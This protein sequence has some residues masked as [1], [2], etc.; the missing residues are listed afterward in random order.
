MTSP[1]ADGKTHRFSTKKSGAL[2]G[3]AAIFDMLCMIG[4]EGITDHD[5]AERFTENEI[6]IR[7]MLEVLKDGMP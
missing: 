3:Y 1:T 5:L 2:R 7:T 4:L 6:D